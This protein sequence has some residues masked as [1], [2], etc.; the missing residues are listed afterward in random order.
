MTLLPRLE[1]YTICWKFSE[2]IK[3]E[4]DRNSLSPEAR[5]FIALARK[6]LKHLPPPEELIVE[7]SFAFA[8]LTYSLTDEESQRKANLVRTAFSWLEEWEVPQ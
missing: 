7:A 3:A 5:S 8:D 1:P 2:I 4:V 6:Y